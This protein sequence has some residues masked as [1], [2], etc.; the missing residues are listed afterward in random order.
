MKSIQVYQNRRQFIGTCFKAAAASAT[1]PWPV[2]FNSAAGIKIARIEVFPVNYPMVGRFK[3]FEGPQGHMQGRAAALIKITADDGSV[4]WGESV[5]IPKWSYET[6][7]TVTSTIRNYLAPE[8]IGRDVFDI[9]G[10]H[11]VMNRN[12]APSFATGQP[13]AKAGVDIA[14]HDLIGKITRQSIPQMWQRKPAEKIKLSWTLNPKKLTD[15]DGLIAE[16][17]KRGYRHFNVKVAPDPAFDIEMCKQLR[18]QVPDCF[19]WADAN[20]GYDTETAMQVAPKLADVG[21]DVL[22]QPLSTNRISG[23]R[24]L[25]KQGALPILMDEGVVS[26]ETLMEFIRLD[27]LDGVAMKP[28]RC[29]GLISA[30]RQIEILQDAGLIFLGSGLTD[31]DISLAATLALYGA[32]SY[33]RPAALNGPQFIQT[34]VLQHPLSVHNGEMDV[35][36]KPG[37]G[38]IVDETKIQDIL[39]NL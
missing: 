18:K 36:G 20:G 17:Q 27:M 35:P 1:V 11:Q 15:L 24:A 10:A 4:G 5:P 26:P 33:D 30:K 28:A 37:L 34:S 23:Y 32:F 12:I 8:L 38:I 39:V 9:I 13:I 2:H 7:E 6:L 21:V 25:K 14:L 3:F 29:G 22:E 31:P 19:L 16:G